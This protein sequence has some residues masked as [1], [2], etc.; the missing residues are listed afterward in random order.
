MQQSVTT[1]DLDLPFISGIVWVTY[2]CKFFSIYLVCHL[3]RAF[4]PPLYTPNKLDIAFYLFCDLKASIN[5]LEVEGEEGSST[6]DGGTGFSS[7]FWDP[8]KYV[9]SRAR[10]YPSSY[11]CHLWKM[12]ST[13][14]HSIGMLGAFTLK[15]Y[16]FTHLRTLKI[17]PLLI[18]G[19]HLC[20]F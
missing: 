10:L 3:S 14:D 12:A 19:P 18:L 2:F 4:C 17:I 15:D 8:M 6:V 9:T 20:T 11:G 7:F 1:T 16:F 13:Y 5:R